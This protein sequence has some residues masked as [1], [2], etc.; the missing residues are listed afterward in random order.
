MTIRK[1]LFILPLGFSLTAMS[2]ST[3]TDQ[4]ENQQEKEVIVIAVNV[5]EFAELLKKGEGQLLD[6]RT[7]EEWALGSIKGASK[8]NFFEV[9]FSEQLNKL[10]KTKPV[11]V[12]CKSG[13]RSG[14]AAKQLEKKDFTVYNLIGGISAW[15][16]AGKTIVK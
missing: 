11:Y 13:G 7:P 12:Y 6:V 8:I 5:T 15:K 16:A 4:L 10:D 3:N 1:L 9:N 14:K 2:C